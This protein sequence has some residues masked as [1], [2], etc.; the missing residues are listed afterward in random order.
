MSQ[1]C[2][3]VVAA[4]LAGGCASLGGSL[5]GDFAC[6]APSG[7]C[8]PLGAIDQAALA[9]LLEPSAEARRPA[10]PIQ[11]LPPGEGE[12][13]ART[14]ERVLT[15]IFPAHVDRWGVLHDAATAHAVA[16]A[17]E[18]RA[19]TGASDPD[20]TAS[21]SAAPLTLREAIAGAS[22][23]PIEGLEPLPTRAPH[24]DKEQAIGAPS[25]AAI[26]AARAGHRIGS[27]GKDQ[28]SPE[29]SAPPRN[30]ES[31][32]GTAAEADRAGAGD[33]FAPVEPRP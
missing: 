28:T 13:P 22:A 11:P 30:Q 15:I 7:S 6:R 4:L 3:I 19:Q 5:R 20:M 24:S 17:P 32:S 29:A 33:P 23:P 27:A 8:A 14:P 18:W 25:A 31:H 2:P 10:A 9:S 12:R 1:R 16:G 26:A 21:R